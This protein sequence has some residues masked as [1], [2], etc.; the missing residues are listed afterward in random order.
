ML[1]QYTSFLSLVDVNLAFRTSDP[2]FDQRVPLHDLDTLRGAVVEASKVAQVREAVK[3]EL[4]VIFDFQDEIRNIVEE[5]P[6]G[7]ANTL[8]RLK[9]DLQST[10]ALK[11]SNGNLLRN[12]NVEGVLLKSVL[13]DNT[14]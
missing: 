6:L 1:E 12:I 5:V 11:D 10:F 8:V 7:P 9:S 4:E 2:T 13:S 3:S 14:F